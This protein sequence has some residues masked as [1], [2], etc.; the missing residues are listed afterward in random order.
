MKILIKNDE[1]EVEYCVFF[2]YD[3][4]YGIIYFSYFWDNCSEED[5][6]YGLKSD[7]FL[8]SIGS[9]KYLNFKEIN[10]YLKKIN[11]ILVFG[12][13]KQLF[14]LFEDICL[15]EVCKCECFGMKKVFVVRRQ[16]YRKYF[17]I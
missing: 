6:V 1:I 9:Y 11:K 2:Y 12:L 10:V 3:F 14:M 15:E 16:F 7:V 4:V 17:V 5:K 8:R 13:V